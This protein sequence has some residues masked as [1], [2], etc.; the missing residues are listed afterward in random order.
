M[1][2]VVGILDL[3]VSTAEPRGKGQLIE[4]AVSVVIEG[5]AVGKLGFR[6]GDS[7][8]QSVDNELKSRLIVVGLPDLGVCIEGA[9][10]KLD[11]S[12]YTVLVI[13]SV[14]SYSI[15]GDVNDLIQISVD[16]VGI[17]VPLDAII[18]YLAYSVKCVVLVA[19]G[20]A[21]SVGYFVQLAIIVFKYFFV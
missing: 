1:K 21:V 9:R 13:V 20:E 17:L 5:I 10:V 2:C 11:S 3:A 12:C 6:R 16:V 18:P 7:I 14:D 15:L 8:R 19:F 4:G